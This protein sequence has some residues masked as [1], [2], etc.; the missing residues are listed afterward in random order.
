MK[1]AEWRG[2]SDVV[3]ERREFDRLG[4]GIWYPEQGDREKTRQALQHCEPSAVPRRV[5]SVPAVPEK[6]GE[7]AGAEPVER[8]QPLGHQRADA[9]EASPPPADG[10]DAA[11]LP[12]VQHEEPVWVRIPLMRVGTHLRSRSDDFLLRCL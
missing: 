2:D 12:R 1:E 4:K 11:S 3:S 10:S 8:C 6:K 7:P 9:Q 5:G